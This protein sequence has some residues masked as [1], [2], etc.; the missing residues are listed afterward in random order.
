[1]NVLIVEDDKL[2]S[3]L[4]SRIIEKLGMTVIGTAVSGH[5][6][7]SMVKELNPDLILMD[8][9]L[10]GEMD[11]IEAVTC[12]RKEEISTPV[13]YITGHSNDYLEE[14]AADTNFID[15]LIK[16]VSFEVLKKSIAKVPGSSPYSS[17]VI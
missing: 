1:M 15:Y 9:I 11:G 13:I 14:R 3:L 17:Y 10:E 5:E 16:P 6:A 12:L 4:H 8:I 2:L 7:I